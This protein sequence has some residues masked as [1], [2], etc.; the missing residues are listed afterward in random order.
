MK[1]DKKLCKSIIEAVHEDIEHLL[2]VKE[3][4]RE[5]IIIVDTELGKDKNCPNQV[6]NGL[7]DLD[8]VQQ[9][10]TI[11][12]NPNSIDSIEELVEIITHEF[13]HL[14]SCEFK[15]LLDTACFLVS[16]KEEDALVQIFYEANEHTTNN[17]VGM[18]KK[19]TEYKNIVDKAKKI[20]NDYGKK[21]SGAN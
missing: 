10:F 11:R 9:I 17:I 2:S 6:Q 16:Q 19:T 21:G 1:I 7:C 8:Y 18:L 3:K 4:W 12:I 20:A 14:V 5:W 13:V 15:R